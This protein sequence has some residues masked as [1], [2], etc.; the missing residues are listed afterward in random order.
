MKSDTKQVRAC[1]GIVPRSNG[2]RIE[3]DN[4][5]IY[6]GI[7]CHTCAEPVAFDI[8]PYPSSFGPGTASLKS[9]A[10]RCRRGHYNVYLPR[11]FQ[12]ISSAVPVAAEVIQ[13]NRDLFRAINP[14]SHVC[15]SDNR[16]PA[17]KTEALRREVEIFGDGDD[18][19]PDE[20]KIVWKSNLSH[21]NVMV[22]LKALRSE[23]RSQQQTAS[24]TTKCFV[25]GMKTRR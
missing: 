1:E 8:G 7:S 22:R 2:V 6:W 21:E 23:K 15:Y 20:W 18:L 5:T 12:F 4:E 9:G 17:E 10:M 25:V 11:D 16:C 24:S 19:P 14:S 3:L 13:E